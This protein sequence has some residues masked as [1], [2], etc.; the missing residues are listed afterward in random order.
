MKRQATQDLRAELLLM[1][2]ETLLRPRKNLISIFIQR[3]RRNSSLYETHWLRDIRCCQSAST[4]SFQRLSG[5]RMSSE[6]EGYT[7]RTG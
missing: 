7:T 4:R 5:V 2:V 1:L 6:I 3:S